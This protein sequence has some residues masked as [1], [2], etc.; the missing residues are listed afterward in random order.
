MVGRSAGWVSHAVIVA[1]PGDGRTG[2]VV[3]PWTNDGIGAVSFSNEL[4]N[5]G[6]YFNSP[7]L[8]EQED[9]PESPISGQKG[10]LFFDDFL[11]FGD[12]YVEW[13]TFDHPEYGEVELGG[14]KKLT[15][16]CIAQS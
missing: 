6:Q 16:I 3:N 9:D 8:Q 2:D 15:N 5:G 14:W 10:R 11:E 13:E 1:R 4:W 7:L 12:N